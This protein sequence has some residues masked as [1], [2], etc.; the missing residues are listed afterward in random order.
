MN[1]DIFEKAF[2]AI[3]DELIADAK[4]PSIR[5]AARRK[6]IMISS[7]AACIAAVS[8]VTPS[9]LAPKS[10]TFIPKLLIFS[11]LMSLFLQYAVCGQMPQ[12]A[13]YLH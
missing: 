3:D 1:N 10:N 7:I 8:S 2:D 13:V 4:N 12:R 11:L 5:I 6:K 9:P